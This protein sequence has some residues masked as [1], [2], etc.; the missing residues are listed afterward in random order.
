M[1]NDPVLSKLLALQDDDAFWAVRNAEVEVIRAREREEAEA[2]RL[3]REEARW[4]AIPDI[5]REEFVPSKSKLGRDAIQHCR[6]WSPDSGIGIGLSGGTGLGKT[7]LLCAIL[8][9][10]RA[11]H[12]W[13]YLPAF[14]MSNL[15][16]NQ[17]SDDDWTAMGAVR[18]LNR[19]KRVEILVLD[20]VGDEKSTEAST[21][22][23][24]ELVERRMSKKLPVLWST[25]LSTDML[26]VKHGPQGAAV[27]RRLKDCCTNF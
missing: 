6:N 17:W 25:N 5:Y 18:Q 24:K 13:M 21:T 7:R 3:A 11:S 10:F 2:R 12:S 9:R 19:S 15:V 27:V 16:A 4:K 26:A 23:F 8:R 14:E 20:D 22:F 1:T